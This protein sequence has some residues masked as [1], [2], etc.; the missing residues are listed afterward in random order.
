M[1]K[2]SFAIPFVILIS[3]LIG[4]TNK[5][6]NLSENRMKLVNREIISMDKSA[7]SVM[8]NDMQG[9]GLAILEDV[10]FEEGT[11]EIELKG[12]NIRGKSFVGV[13][14]NIQND[15]TYEAIY[16]RPFNFQAK[17]QISRE[18]S[19]QYISH[20]DKT[21]RFLRTNFE[22]KYEAEYP[23]K[24]SPE[25]WFGIRI[26]INDKSVYVYD[27]ETNTELLM[28]ERIEKQKSDR[29]ALWMGN[30]SKGAFRNMKVLNK[31]D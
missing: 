26:F 11:I 15:S 10:E 19:V 18:H 27:V 2:N 25:K 14:F 13:A 22:G 28:V 5:L 9:D 1:I 12:E 4:C 8:L 3:F 6:V 21:W 7:K 20:P 24:P 17:E 31:K 16:F 30:N 23:R 29:I